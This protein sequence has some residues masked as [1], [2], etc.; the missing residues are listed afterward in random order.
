MDTAVTREGRPGALARCLGLAPATALVVGTM[1]GTGIYLKPA[2]TAQQ[3]GSAA[4]ALAAWAAGGLLSL[5][6]ALVYLELATAMPEAGADYAYFR[7]GLHPA[8]G[9]LYGW[10]GAVVQGPA[11]ASAFAAGIARFATYFLPGLDA[12][13][14]AAGALR[15]SRGQLLA[16]T[17]VLG[18]GAL[19]L[20]PVR[21]VGWLQVLL[22]ALKVGALAAVVGL[23]LFLGP[24]A[25][26]A[27]PAEA[28]GAGFHAPGFL[29]AVTGTLWAYSGWHT[30]LLVG[31]E[32]AEPARTLPR[33]VLGGFGLTVGL[34]L[35]VNLAC[36]A[37][38][39]HG[40]VARS[41]HPVADLLERLAGRSA[42]GWLTAAMILS[43]LGSLNASLLGTSR[44][45]YA[46]ARDGLLPPFLGRVRP[47]SRVP[48][49]AVLY[50]TA[51]A[52]LLV[53]TGSFESLTAF[54]VFTQWS[55]FA[56]GAVA[57]FRLR[58]LEP[59]LPRPARVPGYPVLPALFL[60]LAGLLT[61]HAVV[62]R[63]WRSAAGLGLIL[64][65][66]PFYALGRRRARAGEAS[67][68]A[69][70]GA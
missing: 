30:L 20:L 54:F 66:L 16:A 42:S 64:A 44:V 69:V 61:V 60:A 48:A 50:T 34:F 13:V 68:A 26:A 36:L 27:L 55:F 43:A 58:R 56:L 14:L 41:P 29:A 67:G 2:E 47:D 39:G 70:S 52:T 22:S 6:G 19:N 63:P 28:P 3:A 24:A 15:L 37:V 9:F 7:R 49:G 65:G 59:D 35:L 23:A 51:F 33:A 18:F 8:L 21:K 12:P 4:W 53:L 40:A 25:R 57:L 62:R 5:L 45:P 17:L 38:L 11:S 1:I 10:K 31:S 32:V 46:M